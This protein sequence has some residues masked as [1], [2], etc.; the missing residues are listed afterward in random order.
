[1]L[2]VLQ[3]E[4]YEDSIPRSQTRTYCLYRNKLSSNSFVSSIVL[5]LILTVITAIII[6]NSKGQHPSPIQVE[7]PS[8]TFTPVSTGTGE[9]SAYKFTILQ[10]ADIHLGE[11]PGT[12]W[13]PIQDIKTWRAMDT[14]LSYTHPNF[15]IF[16]GDQNTANDIKDNATTYYKKLGDFIE[17]YRIPRGIIFGNHDDAHYQNT[18]T[19]SMRRSDLLQ[20]LKQQKYNYCMTRQDSSPLNVFGVSNYVLNVTVILENNTDAIA[21]QIMLL[22]S[23]GGTF[24]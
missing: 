10:I 5:L 20:F 2:Q 12:V 17:S 11:V 1:M 22:D 18:T 21:A 24:F 14:I 8:L 13:G 9:T 3:E 4:N 15:I 23:G 19:T 7:F 16:S 6:F